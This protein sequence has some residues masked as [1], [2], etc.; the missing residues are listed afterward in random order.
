MPAG[1][2]DHPK[3]Q[4]SREALS[5]PRQIALL[6]AVNLAG[7][8][9]VAMSSLRA[10]LADLGFTHART[11]LQ[12]GNVL[13]ESNAGDGTGLEQR[14]ESEAANRLGLRTTFFVRT[15]AEWVALIAANPFQE[16]AVRDPGH[17]V[18][19]CLKTPPTLAAVTALQAAIKGPELVRA[20][21]RHVYITYPAG[22]GKSRLTTAVIERALG[23][24]GTGRNWNTVLKLAA[25]AAG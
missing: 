25:L 17:L 2:S 3:V 22:I 18:A 10:F 8:G 14:L 21:N 19:M 6:R 12:S 16:E 11:L 15:V 9:A 7:H 13:F 4:G 23:G 1:S 24:P 5:M 20:G